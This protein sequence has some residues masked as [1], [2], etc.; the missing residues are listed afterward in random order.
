MMSFF[1]QETRVNHQ[2]DD[3]RTFGYSK[4]VQSPSR[5][6]ASVRSLAEESEADDSDFSYDPEG[7][8][9]GSLS[10]A[11][12][13][14]STQPCFYPGTG[15]ADRLGGVGALGRNINIPWPAHGFG[16]LEYC[17]I[18][19]R[20]LL[21]VIDNFQPDFVFIASGF[22]AVRGD[23]LGSMNVTP[24][25]FA[26]MTELILNSVPHGRVVCTLEGGYN[27]S[28]VAL[29]AESV[30]RTLLGGKAIQESPILIH[31]AQ[32]LATETHKG[33]QPLFRK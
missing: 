25:G 19:E 20:I 13:Y 8:S 31:R 24:S 33:I 32:R 6:G 30:I 26:R 22:D 18:V 9:C 23:T 29:C 17:Y 11:E 1:T 7:S 28:Q 5:D 4:E 2:L 14:D 3:V 16:D 12:T 21:P 10:N 27:V 15:K